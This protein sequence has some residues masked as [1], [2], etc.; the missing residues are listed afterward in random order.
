MHALTALQS[1][2]IY[3]RLARRKRHV[4]TLPC[5]SF[6]VVL[7]YGVFLSLLVAAVSGHI[8]YQKHNQR[9]T[10]RLQL[11]QDAALSDDEDEGDTVHNAGMLDRPQRQYRLNSLFDR[12]FSELGRKCARF[13]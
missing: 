7:I 12:G 1:A 11:L 6:S 9:K 13:P 3:P 2:R 10:E 4:G 5:L 8:A